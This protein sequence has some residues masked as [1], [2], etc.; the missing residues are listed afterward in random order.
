TSR[1]Y[2]NLANGSYTFLVEARDQ[3]TNVDATPASQ[4]FT[5][6]ASTAS[7]ITVTAPNGGEIWS[8]NSRPTI[9]WTSSGISG[10]VSIQISR[11]GGSSWSNISSSTANDGAQAWKVSKP[12][13]SSARIRICSVANPTLCDMSE[14]TFTIK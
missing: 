14:G 8:V 2:S 9:K 3:A 6:N 11:D 5:V 1:S 10:N 7:S 4:T 13:T 12:A